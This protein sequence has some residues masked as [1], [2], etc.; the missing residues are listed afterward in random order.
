MSI[1]EELADARRQAGLSVTE[2]SQQTKIRETIV[3]GIERDDFA[4]CGGDFYARGFIRAIARTVGTDPAP[5][6][7]DYDAAHR[8]PPPE[9]PAAGLPRPVSAVGRDGHRR[10]N[11]T[12][13]LALALAVAV[14]FACYQVFS[15]S[16]RS[17]RGAGQNASR[18]ATGRHHAVAPESPGPAPGVS[19]TVVT[20]TAMQDCWVQFATPSGR[21]LFQSYVVAGAA[22]R[23]T[24]RHVVDM[25]LGN[26]GGVKLLVNGTSPLRPGTSH[27]VTL[28]IGHHRAAA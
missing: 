18:V 3:R 13:V 5:F 8:P 21:V 17:P 22:K 28:L 1:G 6:I 11:V 19:P 7:Q 15:G 23:W 20:L 2:V 14:A 16:A 9:D 27:P 4:T 24:F 10:L 25:T 26:P 12:V